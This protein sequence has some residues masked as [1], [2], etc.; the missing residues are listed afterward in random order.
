MT[1]MP[2]LTLMQWDFKDQLRATSRQAVNN[3]TP[4][5]TFYVYDAS[6]SACAR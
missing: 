3:G 1:A 6:A 5:T 4:E 2:H